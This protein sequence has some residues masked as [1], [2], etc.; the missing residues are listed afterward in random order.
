MLRPMVSDA[1]LSSSAKYKRPTCRLTGL[2]RVGSK[3]AHLLFSFSAGKL[4]SYRV[5]RLIVNRGVIRQSSCKYV[6]LYCHSMPTLRGVLMVA[7]LALPSRNEAK[8][9][10]PPTL[11]LLCAGNAVLAVLKLMFPPHAV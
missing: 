1:A 5:P 11:R 8:P 4:N 2:G 3:S 9:I 10:P 6:A 7:L